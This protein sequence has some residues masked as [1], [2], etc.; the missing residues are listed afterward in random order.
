[1]FLMTRTKW[2]SQIFL[3]ESEATIAN[4]FENESEALT[5]NHSD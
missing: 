4:A 5:T 2:Q 3:R 1:M